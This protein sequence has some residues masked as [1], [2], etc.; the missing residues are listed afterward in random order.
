MLK[1]FRV[2]TLACIGFGAVL[3][4]AASSGKLN[5]A[6]GPRP[7]RLALRQRPACLPFPWKGNGAA[8]TT[9]RRATCWRG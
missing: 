2:S 6:P 1:D 4:Y 8:A 5:R 9:W 7:L 3:G